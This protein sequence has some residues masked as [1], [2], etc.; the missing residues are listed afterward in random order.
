[1]ELVDG[2][3]LSLS[4]TAGWLLDPRQVVAPE[5]TYALSRDDLYRFEQIVG[6]HRG[7]P[8]ASVGRILAASV[9]RLP[10]ALQS[11]WQALSVYRIAFDLTAA[12]AMRATVTL[13]DLWELARRSLLQEQPVEGEVSTLA[14]RWRFR[15]SPLVQRFAQGQAGDLTEAHQNAIFY[16]LSHLNSKP[17]QQ[18]A[19]LTNHLEVFHHWCELKQYIHAFK[20]IQSCD[21]FLD[22]QG[23][24]R[25]LADLYQSLVGVWQ[26]GEAEQGEFSALL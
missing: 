12:Q 26:P 9:A 5:V 11:L 19:D 21:N 10:P 14:E 1:V 8:E 17:W 6:D 2:Q 7:D 18:L 16:Y 3:P 23:H 13:D 20:I 15:F 22:L 25:I 4:L 24:N